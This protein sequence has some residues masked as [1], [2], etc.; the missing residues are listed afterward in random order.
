MLPPA[1]GAPLPPPPA[2]SVLGFLQP[3]AASVA[4]SA[5]E[6]ETADTSE[7]DSLIRCLQRHDRMAVTARDQTPHAAI[8]GSPHGKHAAK[9]AP[10]EMPSRDR[11]NNQ[12]ARRSAPG[13]AST[14]RENATPS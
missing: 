6:I 10:P 14:V 5:V 11:R 12:L 7:L 8:A 3:A 4:K 1:P 2:P 9:P 13:N